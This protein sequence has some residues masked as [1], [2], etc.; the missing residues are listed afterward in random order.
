MHGRPPRAC[1][2]NVQNR[3]ISHSIVEG[4]F[5]VSALQEEFLAIRPETVVI[6]EVFRQQRARADELSTC[7]FQ[8]AAEN[9]SGNGRAAWCCTAKLH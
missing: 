9:W 6:A 3:F 4:D 5:I 1:A 7:G 8:Y 2:A